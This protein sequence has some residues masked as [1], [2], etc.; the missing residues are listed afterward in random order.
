MD[1]IWTLVLHGMVPVSLA[2]LPDLFH[3]FSADKPD[4]VAWSI[5]KLFL[6]CFCVPTAVPPHDAS[7]HPPILLAVSI[8]SQRVVLYQEYKLSLFILILLILSLLFSLSASSPLTPNADSTLHITFL[9]LLNLFY[10]Y[11]NRPLSTIYKASKT[12]VRRE[13]GNT[14]PLK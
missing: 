14:P 3:T 11:M 5:V 13:K 9:Y 1:L 7:T 6:P 2:I 8:S 12:F 10:S 4:G